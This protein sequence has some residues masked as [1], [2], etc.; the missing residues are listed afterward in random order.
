EST[1]ETSTRLDS[2]CLA[3]SHPFIHSGHGPVRSRR[4][5]CHLARRRRGA[6]LSVP[7]E[8]PKADGA[9][10]GCRPRSAGAPVAFLHMGDLLDGFGGLSPAHRQARWWMSEPLV[11]LTEWAA[12]R[13]R[14]AAGKACATIGMVRLGGDGRAR[15]RG[16][17]SPC[18]LIVLATVTGIV[19]SG[20]HGTPVPKQDHAAGQPDAISLY[21]QAFNLLK[22][23][24]PD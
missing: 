11:V 22:G 20:A 2:R 19:A 14:Y 21:A 4:T 15:I 12:A 16:V 10:R 13:F 6:T 24:S 8:D 18:V 23:K 5:R 7:R 9:P 3:T 1:E 17:M